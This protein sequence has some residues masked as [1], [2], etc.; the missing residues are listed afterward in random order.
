MTATC[1]GG[2]LAD[3]HPAIF[4]PGHVRVL[5]EMIQGKRW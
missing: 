5:I 3:A 4:E 2:W 1:I